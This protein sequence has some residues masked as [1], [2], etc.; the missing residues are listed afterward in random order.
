MTD[1]VT[2]TPTLLL[3]PPEAAYGRDKMVPVET[4]EDA[5]QAIS[6]GLSALLPAGGWEMAAETLDRLGVEQ[7]WISRLL[8]VAGGPPA[9]K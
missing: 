4:A 2:I 6:N 1:A 8:R 7:D 9:G 5:F 3:G